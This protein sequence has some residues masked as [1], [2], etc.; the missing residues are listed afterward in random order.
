MIDWITFWGVIIFNT[1]VLTGNFDRFQKWMVRHAT[2]D[3]RIQTIMLAWGGEVIR[4]NMAWTLIVLA[5]LVGVGLLYYF[6][7]PSVMQK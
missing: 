1:L 6:L 7:Y 2:A 5:Y 3:I 4:H